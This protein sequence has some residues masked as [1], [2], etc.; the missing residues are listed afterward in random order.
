MKAKI[1]LVIEKNRDFLSL[2]SHDRTHLFRTTV[3][4]TT[5]IGGI[6]TLRQH[7]LFDYPSFCKSAVIIF[8]PASSAF[9]KRIINLL[10]P[11]NIFIKLIL[12]N[13]F[14]L[15]NQLYKHSN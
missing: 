13:Y 5:T 4:F 8:R 2:C 15:D 10:D 3:E 12:A 7:Q 6:F 14:F 11:D 9:T 1:E